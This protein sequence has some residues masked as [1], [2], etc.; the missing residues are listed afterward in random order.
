MKEGAGTG[1]H[2]GGQYGGWPPAHG[3]YPQY[4]QNG[5]YPTNPQYQQ[6]SPYQQGPQYNPQYPFPPKP[7][8]KRGRRLLGA[9]ALG[10]AAM[11]VAGSVAWGIDQHSA[12]N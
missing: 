7:P 8:K 3:G 1:P 11:V 4:P 12:A 9:G 10:L 2:D 6:G 5:P